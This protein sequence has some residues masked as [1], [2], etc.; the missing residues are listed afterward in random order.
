MKSP[1]SN[2]C[3]LALAILVIASPGYSLCGDCDGNASVNILD[4]LLAAQIGTGLG[5]LS[6]PAFEDCNVQGIPG[7]P[8]QGAVGILDAL[9]IAQYTV[10]RNGARTPK[11]P[12]AVCF[13]RDTTGRN[14]RLYVCGGL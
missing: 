11:N 8:P 10:G 4:A 6:T 2:T 14:L 3:A 9:R 5:I 12:A 7:G 13:F 1:R